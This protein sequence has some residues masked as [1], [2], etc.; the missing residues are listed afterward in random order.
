MTANEIILVVI[1][2]L[3]VIHGLFLATI[4]WSYTKGNK[5]SNKLL[6]TLLIVL[7]FRIGKSVFLAFIDDLDVKIIFSGL[8]TIMA[9]GPLYLFLVKSVID[10]S[11]K[12]RN[13]HHL[14]FVPVLLG[15]ILGLLLE[16]SYLET[17]PIY[18][19]ALLFLAYYL[20]FLI[21]IIVG[22]K[23]ARAYK[24]EGG[25]NDAFEFIRLLFFGLL[26]LWVVYVLNLF[27]EDIPY[28]IGPI[29]YSAVAYGLSFLIF[30]RDYIQKIG[31]DKYKSNPI[32][33]DQTENIYT[34]VLT[35]VENDEQYKDSEIS[36]KSMSN[37]IN[38]SPQ[39][40]SLVINQKSGK[41]FNA[42]INSYRI[43]EAK[44]MLEEESYSNYTVSSIAFDVGFNSISSFNSAFKKDTNTTPVLY[45]NQFLK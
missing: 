19:F 35:A 17:L 37:A 7:S 28:I 26:A 20:H 14:H 40:L 8:S 41:N 15:F 42:F 36:L 18:L 13:E 25:S 34:K 43:K 5:V 9:I 21:Y 38:V 3:G 12:I 44:R 31:H 45:R 33:D 27:D 2:G 22:Y 11:F 24:K 30:K 16:E 4:L 39:I 29:L 6:G 23:Q 32:S 1:Y 10:K